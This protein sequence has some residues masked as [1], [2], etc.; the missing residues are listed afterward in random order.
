MSSLPAWVAELRRAAVDIFRAGVAAADPRRA[1]EQ[2]LQVRNGRLA[3]RRG[4]GSW[5][6]GDW[7][8]IRLVAFGKAACAMTEGALARLEAAWLADQP[9]VVTNYENLRELPGCRVL[10]AGHPLPDDNGER[11]ARAVAG[12]V[13]A[14]GASNELVLVLISGG[15]SALLPA[16][17]AGLALADKIAT[18]RLLLACGADIHAVNCV[19]K[20]LSSLK[21]GALARLAA[22]AEVHALILSDVLDDD[23]SVIASG[24]TVPDSSTYADAVAVLRRH[25]VWEQVPEPV[26][27][28]LQRGLAGQVADTP[29]PG[30]ALFARVD[31]TLVGSN[32]LSLEAARR[33]AEALGYAVTL[34]DTMLCGEARE[35]A[36][37]LA[38]AALA[39]GQGGVAL[40]AGGE[41][42]VTL[43]GSGRGGRN[44]ELALAFVL[45]AERLSLPPRWAFLSGGTD[46][47]DGPT[48]AAGG[49]VDPWTLARIQAAGADPQRLLD[50]NDSYT[51]L[52]LAGDLLRSG[53][54]GTNV[55]DL[56]VLL[57]RSVA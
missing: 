8:R 2:A 32:R 54:T 3:I 6:E 19:R 51:A 47:R 18:T 31:N 29:K 55:A 15:G 53:A 11:A 38:R 30:D 35:A 4:D 17:A 14:A 43:R 20:H 13:A 57:L 52:D 48:D 37:G 41:T 42:T 21:G 10:G 16:P 28:H 39:A 9:I 24:P 12:S 1:V 49:V 23:L 34:H 7:R 40:L 45:A 25:G 36:E 22:P 50:D 5:R 46:G 33:A 44:Q 56:Q 26:R 27:A